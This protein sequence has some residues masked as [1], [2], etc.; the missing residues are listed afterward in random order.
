MN[1]KTSPFNILIFAILW[2]FTNPLIAHEKMYGLDHELKKFYT[3]EYSVNN[4]DNVSINNRYG[5]IDVKTWAKQ[6]VKIEVHVIV[7]ASSKSKAEEK[8]EEI[9]IYMDKTGDKVSGRTEIE[10]SNQSWWS[11]W[12]I[13]DTNVKLEINY[14]VFMPENLDSF[15]ENKYGNIYLPDLKANSNIVLKYGN[16]QANNIWGDCIMELGYGKA[17]FGTLR[18]LTATIAYSD[19]TCTSADAMVITSKYSKLQADQLKKLIA[20]SKYDTYKIRASEQLTLTGAYDDIEIGSVYNATV[21]LKYTGLDIDN[22]GGSMTANLSYGSMTIQAL[23][24][25]FKK[26]VVSSSYAPIKIYGSV[27]A[28]IDI[29]GKYFDANLGSDFIATKRDVDG[30]S[31][32]IQGHKGSDRANASI[33]INTSYGDVMIK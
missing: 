23:K 15:L 31:K 4:G 3:K 12:W 6:S 26:M 18:N 32:F 13:N 16:L 17:T 20:T 5:K 29:S 11:S 24:N 2:V 14:T 25:S 19:I 10:S 33:T 21:T 1:T 22:L 27:P 28:K 30:S 8:H 7:K 9:K